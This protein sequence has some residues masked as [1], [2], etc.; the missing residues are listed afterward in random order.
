MAVFII[1]P[2]QGGHVNHAG[3]ANQSFLSSVNATSGT[4]TN[5]VNASGLNSRNTSAV[6]TL[7]ASG[8]NRYY[9]N[10]TFF[11]FDVSSITNIQID[12]VELKIVTSLSTTDDTVDPTGQIVVVESDAFNAAGNTLANSDF[13]NINKDVVYNSGIQLDSEDAGLQSIPL[14]NCFDAIVDNSV[15]QCGIITID[16]FNEVDPEFNGSKVTGFYFNDSLTGGQ[17]IQLVIRTAAPF[18]NGKIGYMHF[19]KTPLTAE[20]VRQNYNALKHRFK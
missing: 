5:R 7:Y 2:N 8:Q 18:F 19:N 1:N 10:R 14:T 15:F 16:D 12:S 6:R 3:G 17:D 20:E 4:A 13:D 11:R 9:Y